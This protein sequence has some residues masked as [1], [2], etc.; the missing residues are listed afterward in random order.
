[1]PRSKSTPNSR[2]YF[3]VDAPIKLLLWLLLAP[4]AIVT[5]TPSHGSQGLGQVEALPNG[6][7]SFQNGEEGATNFISPLSWCEP[8]HQ[9]KPHPFAVPKLPRLP[10]QYSLRV[11]ANY[12]QKGT[13]T[14][15]E[16]YYDWPNRRA[17][18]AKT[19][20]GTTTRTIFNFK[21]REK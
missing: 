4:L 2:P 9:Y 15:L 20:N 12:A 10:K 17:S 5:F 13:T 19:Y 1:M 18:V 14:E 8:A 6:M 16:G 7:N 21:Q 3:N 11:E